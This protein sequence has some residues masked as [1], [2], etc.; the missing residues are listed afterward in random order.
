MLQMKFRFQFM[1]ELK[2]LIVFIGFGICSYSQQTKI[3]SL[4]QELTKS[5]QDSNKV[6]AL[7][8]L[9]VFLS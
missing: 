1:K 2:A 4:K 6:N 9:G 7:L 8:P 5:E 3:D